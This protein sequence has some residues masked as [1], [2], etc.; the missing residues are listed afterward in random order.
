MSDKEVSTG[1]F[2]EHS[3]SIIFF[4]PPG[5]YAGRV[6]DTIVEQI[7]IPETS[8]GASRDFTFIITDR[9]GDGLCCSWKESSE[10]G[11]TIYEG[12]P[13][14]ESVIVDSKFESSERE[15]KVFTIHGGNELPED[16]TSEQPS[17][18]SFEIKVTIA[19]DVYPDETGFYI[20]DSFNRRVVD[21]PPGTY[22][23]EQSLVEEIIT[24]EA[25]LYTFTMLDSFGDGIN[26]ADGY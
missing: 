16:F 19:L 8:S 21:V 2:G 22:K 24:L 9:Y 25:G 17:E 4:R 6:G 11:Y 12:D 26:R 15:I 5:Y 18:K 10:T 23:D 3:D 1:R 7:P 13:G 20:E 14:Q